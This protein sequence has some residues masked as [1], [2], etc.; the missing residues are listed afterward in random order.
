[1]AGCL[2]DLLVA[3]KAQRLQKLDVCVKQRGR[4]PSRAKSMAGIMSGKEEGGAFRCRGCEGKALMV[5]R[6]GD[7]NRKD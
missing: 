1:M 3:A 4:T 7:M 6:D 2:L 5:L